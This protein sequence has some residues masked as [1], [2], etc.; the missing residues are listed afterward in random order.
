MIGLYGAELRFGKQA[1]GVVRA[2]RGRKGWGSP[3]PENEHPITGSVA[4]AAGAQP[5]QE[6][7]VRQPKSLPT[8]LVDALNEKVVATIDGQCQEIT[9]RETVVT[10]L[11]NKSTA[12][13]LRATKMLI[14]MLKD[15]QAF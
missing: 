9:K 6:G 2:A 7:S 12:A 5:F 8:L 3:I 15:A 14:D 1:A 4:A 13:D 11:V 10:Q